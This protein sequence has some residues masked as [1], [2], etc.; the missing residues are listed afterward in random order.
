[1]VRDG[2]LAE[3]GSHDELIEADGHYAR[4]FAAWRGRPPRRELS[5][6]PEPH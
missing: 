4:L 6:E 2:A 1:V 5:A 3:L